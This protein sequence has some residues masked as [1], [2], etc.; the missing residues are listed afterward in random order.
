MVLEPLVCGDTESWLV[1]MSLSATPSFF[2][3]AMRAD[4]L[5]PF[6]LRASV[7][8]AAV[9]CTPTVTVITLGAPATG[10]GPVAVIPPGVVGSAGRLALAGRVWTVDMADGFPA[11][12]AESSRA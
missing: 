9:V 2:R 1:W 12:R 11:P 3:A 10:A 6:C 4:A 7:A 5:T 8:W